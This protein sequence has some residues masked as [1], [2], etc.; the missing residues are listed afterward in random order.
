[1]TVITTG[2][3]EFQIKMR[4]LLDEDKT[5]IVMPALWKGG[6]RL[7]SLM[8]RRAPQ[9]KTGRL[10]KSIY[11]SRGR[12]D[13]LPQD[14]DVAVGLFTRYY[15]STLDR[16]RAGGFKRKATAKRRAVAGVRGT[17]KFNSKGTGIPGSAYAYKDEVVSVIKEEM[18][19]RMEK[20]WQGHWDQLVR[21]AGG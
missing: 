2:I 7:E 19:K 13:T 1:M 3:E 20:V 8:R 15:Y 16:G 12:K 11:A 18:R 21:D 4:H 17:L 10:K 6:K 9:G 5:K 14:K